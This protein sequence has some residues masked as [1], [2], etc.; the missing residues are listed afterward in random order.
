MSW[1]R[2]IH[3][4]MQ[5]INDYKSIG[6][7]VAGG[8][9]AGFIYS[10]YGFAA[11]RELELMQ[12]AGFTA[13]EAINAYTRQA[14]RTLTEPKGVEP[15]FGMV[16][17]GQMADLIVTPENPLANFKTL[18]GTGT[19]RLN[20]ATGKIERVGGIRW[21]VRNGVV[22]DAKQLLADVAAMVQTQKDAGG[23]A[24]IDLDWSAAGPCG[25]TGPTT[26]PVPTPTATPAPGPAGLPGPAGPVG[27]QGPKGDKGDT[28]NVSISCTITGDGRSISCTITAA[29]PTGDKTT[30]LKSAVRVQNTK[31]TVTR[32]GK[33]KVTVK[34][35]ATKKSQGQK[36]R[37][38]RASPFRRRP[39]TFAADGRWIVA[40]DQAGDGHAGRGRSAARRASQNAQ[41]H[42]QPRGNGPGHAPARSRPSA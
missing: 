3:R 27:P 31:R 20:D 14:A 40:H 38:G 32:S 5:L 37:Q 4:Y 2:F 35:K 19:G 42:R 6:G 12:E 21:T 18:Y 10:L 13:N 39:L 17:V 36:G 7:R 29:P 28:P 34:F 24:G 41:A 15:E 8:T 23:C 26:P 33:G 30:K 25:G 11:I 16:R 1:K 22:Y 9:D